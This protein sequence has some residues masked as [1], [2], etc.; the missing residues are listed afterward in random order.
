MIALNGEKGLEI[1][2][3]MEPSFVL[4]D[5]NLKDGKKIYDLKQIT[6]I[7]HNG[8]TPVVIVSNENLEENRM[9]AYM[10][11]AT[12]FIAKPINYN[13]FIPFMKNRIAHREQVLESISIDELTQTYNRRHM[14]YSLQNELDR[15][16][17]KGS[18]FS[19]VLLDLDYFKHINDSYGHLIGD[20][21]L[22]KLAEILN[23][24]LRKKD[25][26]FRFGGEEFLIL[27]KETTEDEA[28]EII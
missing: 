19:L 6:E 23:V 18:V 2:Y 27:L 13:V 9:A 5:M 10:I 3:T 11:G 1:F 22:K 26:V 12:D 20:E 24:S 17:P 8:F 16:K 7:S 21:V 25:L 15:Y 4:L 28:H 14:Q